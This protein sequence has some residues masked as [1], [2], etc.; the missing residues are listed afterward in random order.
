[1]YEPRFGVVGTGLQCMYSC[2]LIVHVDLA[3]YPVII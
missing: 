3:M 2:R 1:M